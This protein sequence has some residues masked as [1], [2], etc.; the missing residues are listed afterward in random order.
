[1]LENLYSNPNTRLEI[2]EEFIKYG[3]KELLYK[4]AGDIMQNYFSYILFMLSSLNIK[5][6][7]KG[8]MV[9]F[10]VDSFRLLGEFIET[11]NCL[12]KL[13]DI[14]IELIKTQEIAKQFED[15]SQ[16]NFNKD[17]IYNF[18][19]VLMS[20]YKYI[21]KRV[22]FPLLLEQSIYSFIRRITSK[23]W[24][25]GLDSLCNWLW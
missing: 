10:P 14:M 21:L 8:A 22:F 9:P 23:S 25:R 6:E 24:A 5:L 11:H 3:H 20:I 13:L 2:V 18:Y 16:M 19:S 17:L 12:R 15:M 7:Y 1:M 4:H